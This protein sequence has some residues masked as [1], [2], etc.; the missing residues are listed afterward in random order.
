MHVHFI[1]ITNNNLGS[2][3]ST[4]VSLPCD[5]RTCWDTDF[6]DFHPR[7]FVVLQTCWRL[8]TGEPGKNR[9]LFFLSISVLSIYFPCLCWRWSEAER[10]DVGPGPWGECVCVCVCMWMCLHFEHICMWCVSA[11]KIKLLSCLVLSVYTQQI[12]HLLCLWLW[13]QKQETCPSIPNPP[14]FFHTRVPACL[15]ACSP[16][17]HGALTSE[18]TALSSMLLQHPLSRSVIKP[19]RVTFLR[20]LSPAGHTGGTGRLHWPASVPWC[21]DRIPSTNGSAMVDHKRGPR[22]PSQQF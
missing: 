1:K 20:L 7:S 8:E 16:H 22:L 4:T 15:R 11:W 19:S 17:D 10:E 9:C 13:T 3:T 14:M 12:Q 18:A 5:R 21:P 6:Q 2:C